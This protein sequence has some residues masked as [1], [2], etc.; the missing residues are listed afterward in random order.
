MFISHTVY[1]EP[2][3]S[4]TAT[5]MDKHKNIYKNSVVLNDQQKV[6][7]LNSKNNIAWKQ[8][9]IISITGKNIVILDIY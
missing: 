6:N 9:L 3:S 5:Q 8:L 4:N 2:N 1:E 7:K